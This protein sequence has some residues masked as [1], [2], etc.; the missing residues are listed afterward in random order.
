MKTNWQTKTL[1]EIGIIFSGN[2]INER[3]KKEK[4]SGLENGLPFVAT[5][6]INFETHSIDYNNGVSI[7]VS[8]KSFKVAHKNSILICAEG[9][10]AGKK[11]AFNNR[12][13]C[14][15]NKL[16]AIEVSENILPKFVYYWYLTPAFFEAFEYQMSGIIGGISIGNFKLLTISFP[17]LAEQKR[18]VKI[19]DEVFEWI[20]KTKENAEKNL[21]NSQEIFESY[22]QSIFANPGIDWEERSIQEITKV[23]NG[24]SFDGQDFSSNNKIKSVKITNVGVKEF[25]EETE[26]Y[27]PEKYKDTFN[28]YK[29]KEGNIVI[30]L[31]R[32]IISAGLKVAVVPE[33]YDDALLNQRVAA[34]VPIEK[35]VDQ[36]FLYNFLCTKIVVDYVKAHVNTLMQPNLSINDLK[37]IPVP[38]PP[39]VEQ[40]VIVKKLDALSWETKKLEAIFRRK[41]A[42]LDELKKS[43]LKQAFSGEL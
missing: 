4:Y 1:G 14:F 3:V 32:T 11:I 38:C 8:E 7:P 10:S 27:L 36:K 16:L 30:A 22:L 18:I 23:I 29:V 41:I 21:K 9:G 17:P 15:G 42:D 39:L 5:K 43:I 33:C 6:D 12:D 13:V 40:K 19:L 31:T 25:V 37:K 2:S 24:Y 26:N 35:L 34:L 28:A 20:E